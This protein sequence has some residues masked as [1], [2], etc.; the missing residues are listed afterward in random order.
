MAFRHLRRRPKKI[1]VPE[2]NVLLRFSRGPLAEFVVCSRGAPSGGRFGMTLL[3]VIKYVRQVGVRHAFRTL[4]M[5]NE[6]K[7]GALKGVVR[8]SVVGG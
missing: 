2:R 8:T 7:I 1:W 3:D 5:T 4:R 6:L